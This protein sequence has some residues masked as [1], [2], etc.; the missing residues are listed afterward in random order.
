MKKIT[1]LAILLPALL[2]SQTFEEVETDFKDFLFS[3][4]DVADINGNGNMDIVFSGALI[5]DG[6]YITQNEFYVNTGDSFE[7]SHNFEEFSVHE[8]AIRFIDF[9][10]DGLMD[11]VSTGL[12][13]LDIVNYKQYRWENDGNN[14]VKTDETVGRVY[15]NIEVFDMNHNGFQDYAVNGIQYNEGVGYEHAVDYF[16]NTGDGFE[17][18]LE[19]LPGTQFGNF[20]IVDLNNNGELDAVAI[21]LD[22]NINPVFHVYINNEGTLELT[23]EFP[24]VSKGEV[25]YADFNADGFQDLIYSGNDANNNGYLA[26]YFNNGEGG[27]DEILEIENEGLKDSSVAV[28]DFNNDGY[29]DFVIVGNYSS[30]GTQSRTKLFVYDPDT[31]S[32]TKVEDTGLYNIGSGGDVQAFD[33]N[34]D[35]KLDIVMTGFDWGT[36]GSPQLTKLFKNLSTETNEKPNPPTDLVLEEEGNRLNFSWSGATDDKTPT[37]ALRYELT[38]GTTSGGQDIARYVVTT[39]FW[40]LDLNE[41]PSALYWSVKSIDAS[42]VYSDASEEQTLSI[43]DITLSNIAIYPNPATDL[44]TIQGD[45]PIESVVI[46]TLNGEQIGGKFN[47]HTIDVSHLSSGVYLIKIATNDKTTTRKLL[48]K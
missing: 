21:G 19:W 24:G 45:E 5:E 36:G 1:L 37:E 15:G 39:P 42:Y 17:T 6:S 3:S 2:F 38:V 12:S 34:N 40:Y 11:I 27:F 18:H 33:Y 23:H 46:Y 13:Y 22:P 48:V 4:I 30:G 9:N 10:N 8:G 25:K 32:F 29:Y 35:N 14:F 7:L 31:N 44:V 47:G 20:Q 16:E 41:I 28:G 26:V 43:S